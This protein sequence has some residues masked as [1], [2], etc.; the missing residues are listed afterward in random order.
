MYA[1]KYF[2][3]P[4]NTSDQAQWAAQFEDKYASAYKGYMK[5]EQ[6]AADEPPCANAAA[7][8]TVAD[9]KAWQEHQNKQIHTY[10]PEAYQ[11][12]AEKAVQKE[13]DANE[14]RINNVTASNSSVQQ[15]TQSSTA[16]AKKEDDKSSSW[17]FALAAASD[18]Q[19]VPAQ[20]L[21]S[22]DVQPSQPV[23]QTSSHMPAMLAF[24]LSLSMLAAAVFG[25]R[26][27]EPSTLDGYANLPAGYANLPEE[28]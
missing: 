5:N 22:A 28:V 7:C 27:Q 14:L 20:T 18:K 23:E 9:L 8:K 19:E 2:Q 24:V 16:S 13:F 10:V 3:Q 25:K 26:R 21:A 12:G 15:A 11:S 1:S 4:K 6:N 17:P